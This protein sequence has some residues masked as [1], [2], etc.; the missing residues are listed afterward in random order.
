MCTNFNGVSTYRSSGTC[1]FDD[2]DGYSSSTVFLIGIAVVVILV[3]SLT[4]IYYNI[5]VSINNK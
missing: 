2:L 3:F 1:E 4:V 5:Y